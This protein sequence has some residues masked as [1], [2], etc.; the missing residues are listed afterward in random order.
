MDPGS[1]SP[2]PSRSDGV[3]ALP[4]RSE[5][6]SVPPPPAG[7]VESL[8]PS[9]RRYVGDPWL[10]VSPLQAFVSPSPMAPIQRDITLGA[11]LLRK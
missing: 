8:F 11:G 10:L 3:L 4:L 1:L 5:G 9:P 2:P 6:I 7:E